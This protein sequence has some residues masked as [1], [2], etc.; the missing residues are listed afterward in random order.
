MPLTF[1]ILAERHVRRGPS[2][3]SRSGR[4]PSTVLVWTTG[5]IVPGPNTNFNRVAVDRPQPDRPLDLPPSGPMESG[6]A[7]SIGRDIRRASAC[8]QFSKQCGRGEFRQKCIALFFLAS[9]AR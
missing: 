2:P 7:I 8:R 3:T 5:L 4:L 6:L 9:C 1:L